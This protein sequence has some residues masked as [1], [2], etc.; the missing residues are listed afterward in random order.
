MT[1][2]NGTRETLNGYI[3]VANSGDA[4]RIVEIYEPYCE[5]NSAVSFEIV[6]PSLDAMAER[7]ETT[8]QTHP[9][10]V[11]V[12]TDERI[13]NSRAPAADEQ[14][15]RLQEISNEHTSEKVVAYAYAGPHKQRAAYRW[16]ADCSVYIDRAYHG[17]GIGKTLYTELFSML[18]AMNIVNVYAGVT[19]PNPAS[20]GLHKSMGFT[21]VGIY[22]NVGYKGGSWHDVAWLE[23]ALQSHTDEPPEPIAFPA[24]SWQPTP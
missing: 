11:Y 9:W 12:A 23:F 17:K 15:S 21:D 5:Q 2:S 7:I 10:L 20:I 24:L 22:R 18:R 14:R 1:S 8:L 16:S 6:A 3:R 13:D 19:L 4:G